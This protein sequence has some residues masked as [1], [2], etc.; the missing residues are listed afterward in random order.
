MYAKYWRKFIFVAL[1]ASLFG[2]SAGYILYRLFGSNN[3]HLLANLTD[4][5]SGAAPQY[6]VAASEMVV[7]GGIMSE[8]T[9]PAALLI[10]LVIFGMLLNWG[11]ETV[12]WRFL[13]NKVSHMSLKNAWKGVLSGTA[14]SMWMP[15]R[16]GDYLGRILYLPGQHYGKAIVCSILGSMSQFLATLIFGLTGLVWWLFASAKGGS[17][18]SAASGNLT[19]YSEFFTS[20]SRFGSFACFDRFFCI[21]F[22]SPLFCVFVSGKSFQISAEKIYPRFIPVYNMGKIICLK[23][24]RLAIPGFL[25]SVCFTALCFWSRDCLLAGYFYDMGC[26]FGSI[27]YPKLCPY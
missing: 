2:I 22:V 16:M 23:P 11:F 17:I 7:S 9:I 27:A 3:N 20:T 19:G 6:S 24:F 21:V 1:K 14:V 5:V 13:Y 25:T 12:K 26:I 4:V 18:E 8:F 10:L 15:N